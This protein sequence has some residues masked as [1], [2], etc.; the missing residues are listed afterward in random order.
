MCVYRIYTCFDVLVYVK[1]SSEANKTKKK[2][3]STSILRTIYI[4]NR[5]FSFSFKS[6]K[7]ANQ[8]GVLLP[9]NHWLK[10]VWKI[11]ELWNL[12]SKQTKSFIFISTDQNQ[13]NLKQYFPPF[14]FLMVNCYLLNY[15]IF[16]TTKC[17]NVSFT[18]RTTCSQFFSFV[19]S[20]DLLSHELCCLPQCNKKM[21]CFHSI[22]T[23]SRTRFSF[24]IYFVYSKCIP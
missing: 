9:K 10:W 18:L 4:W 21:K 3:Q 2:S 15:S 6:N 16:C 13:Y 24:S 23:K 17:Q 19:F 22:Q 14:P 7:S 20:F 8:F 12:K 1:S 11:T 5:S